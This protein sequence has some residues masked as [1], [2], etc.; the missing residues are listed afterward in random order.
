[1]SSVGIKKK[2]KNLIWD[3]PLFKKN[4]RGIR[5]GYFISPS[6]ISVCFI[7]F[8]CIN[9]LV[10][11]RKKKLNL[12]NKALSISD[13]YNGAEKYIKIISYTFLI[14]LVQSTK[15]LSFIKKWDIWIWPF[16]LNIRSGSTQG[17]SSKHQDYFTW[18]VTIKGALQSVDIN[19]I[20]SIIRKL[21]YEYL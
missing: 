10:E 14:S 2:K 1:M 16:Y 21:Q 15:Q 18:D 8:G 20:L 6:P 3:S 13:L 17:K 12:E 7:Q 5:D 4:I 9:A 11:K 19:Y